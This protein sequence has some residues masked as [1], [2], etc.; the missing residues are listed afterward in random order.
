MADAVGGAKK[1]NG[2]NGHAPSSYAAK[3]NLA[4]HFIGGNEL[5]NA[6]PSKV[7]D[8]VAANDGHT[9]ITKVSEHTRRTR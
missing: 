6:A 5:S 2:V 4:S 3:Y 8:F 7:K 1:A 9:V